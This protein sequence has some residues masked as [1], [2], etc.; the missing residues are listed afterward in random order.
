[1]PVSI[2]IPVIK[3]GWLI[4]CIESVLRQSSSDWRLSLLWDGGDDLSR[5]ILERVERMGHPRLRVFYQERTGIA[6][7]RRFLSSCSSEELILPV[8]DD[9]VLA[10]TAVEELLAAARAMPWCGIIRARRGFIDEAGRP[11][12]MTD[13]FPFEPRHFDRGMTTDLFN[14]SHPYLIRRAAYARTAGWQ[15]F[16]DFQLAGEDC[17]IF[18]QIEEV[19]DIELLDRCLYY[20]RIHPKRTSNQLGPAAAEEM[21]RRLADRTIAR[22]GLPLER[23]SEVQPFRYRRRTRT[24]PTSADIDCVIPF[25]ESDREELPYRFN[26]PAE[27]QRE[28]LFLLDGGGRFLQ[29]L[30]EGGFDQLE[31]AVSAPGAISGTLRIEVHRDSGGASVAQREISAARPLMEFVHLDFEPPVG[32]SRRARME[33]TFRPDRR[34]AHPLGLHVF[35]T[36]EEE[37]QALLLRLF[38]RSPEFSARQ[39]ARCLQSLE[40]VGLDPRSLHVMAKRQ[41][42]AAN[43]NEGFRRATKPLVCFIDDDVEVPRPGIFETLLAGLEGEAAD[44]AGPKI[45]DRAGRIFCADPYFDGHLFPKPRGLGEEDRRQYDYMA[46]VPWLPSTFL[47]I[48]REVWQSIG[49]FDEAYPGSQM[50]DVDF[51][52]NARRKGFRC[53]YV[54][55]AEAVHLNQQRNDCFSENFRRFHQRW[56]Q[57]GDLF[58][59]NGAGGER[60]RGR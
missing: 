16:E 53:L 32:P 52:L 47:L 34:S 49:G 41:S 54:G 11:V 57:R 25:W 50:E 43:K 59:G 31:L 48:R 2:E 58:Q 19:A 28:S 9:D 55:E 36:G 29:E 30:D 8:D 42:S 5:S 24:Q 12:E 10:P 21:W 1:M 33:I 7:S 13:W 26:R 40:R 14:H 27:Q 38:R 3:G 37:G 20:Y 56:R 6:A 35:E 23:F 51:C 45:V 60:G 4:P 39:L 15:G 18:L 44:L 46:E 22:R 17:D